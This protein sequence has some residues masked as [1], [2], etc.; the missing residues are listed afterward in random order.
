MF[1]R[2]HYLKANT[3]QRIEEAWCPYLSPAFQ[4]ALQIIEYGV[5]V[6]NA[7]KEPLQIIEYGVPVINK[8][9]SP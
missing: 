7:F 4:R 6:I 1:L 3:E 8:I 5:P 9:L 2:Q